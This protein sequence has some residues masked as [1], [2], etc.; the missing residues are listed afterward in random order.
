MIYL[1][2][3]NL[4]AVHKDRFSKKPI[5]QFVLASNQFRKILKCFLLLYFEHVKMKFLENLHLRK[6]W[7]IGQKVSFWKSKPRFVFEKVLLLWRISLTVSQRCKFENIKLINCKPMKNLQEERV[8][9][10]KNK[11]KKYAKILSPLLLLI[12]QHVLHLSIVI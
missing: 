7:E 8:F 4:N 11:C 9:V 5:I 1:N 12:C 2:Q 6:A 3:N 10:V